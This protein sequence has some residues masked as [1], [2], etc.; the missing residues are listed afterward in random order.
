[1]N[2]FAGVGVAALMASGVVIARFEED[3]DG[4]VRGEISAYA[5]SLMQA[6]PIS[7]VGPNAYVYANSPLTGSFIPVHNS[8]L[9]A[10]VELG[11]P[12]AIL[13]LM[14][15]AVVVSRAW[16][17]RRLERAGYPARAVIAGSLPVALV[18][19]TGWGMLGTSIFSLAMVVFGYHYG[20]ITAARGPGIPPVQALHSDR[21][22]S[23]SNV[24]PA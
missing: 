18:A 16:G 7:G 3:P 21:L 20:A 5:V 1:M 13:L 14:P 8:F 11:I 9:L 22:P 2:I 23:V 12:G 19:F 15:A 10:A 6:F 4:G 17:A 24:A